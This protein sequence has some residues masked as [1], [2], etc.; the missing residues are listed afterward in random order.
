MYMCIYVCIN[1]YGYSKY[2]TVSLCV[3]FKNL[4]TSINLVVK[5]NFYFHEL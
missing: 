4:N 3:R 5:I 2:V 1:N